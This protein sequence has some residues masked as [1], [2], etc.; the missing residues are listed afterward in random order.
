[1]YILHHIDTCLPDYFCG[2]HNP[3]IQIAVYPDSTYQ[4]I[5]DDLLDIY[6]ATDHIEDLDVDAYKIAVNEAFQGVDDMNATPKACL[7]IES[8]NEDD[9]SDYCESVYMFFALET[10]EDEE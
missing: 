8:Y 2:N 10:I 1:M 9:N 7:W 3:V 6:Q 5:K 4:T